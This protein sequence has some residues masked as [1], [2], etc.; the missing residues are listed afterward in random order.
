M[1][2]TVT[3]AF[4]LQNPMIDDS[5]KIP[6]W[7]RRLHFYSELAAILMLPKLFA[8]ARDANHP[9]KRFLTVLAWGTLVIDGYLV[10]RWVTD[11]QLKSAR[12]RVR[13]AKQSAYLDPTPPPVG[14][15]A[16]P[17]LPMPPGMR[18]P[19]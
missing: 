3:A 19:R 8:A 10:Y 6:G 17:G 18:I 2:H 9:H 14:P 13:F 7:Q 4:G 16:P 15:G 12:Q 5:S 11:A 1:N